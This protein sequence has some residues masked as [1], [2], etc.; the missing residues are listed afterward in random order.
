MKLLAAQGSDEP[1]PRVPVVGVGAE[2]VYLL[3]V[4]AAVLARGKDGLKGQLELGVGA[5][6]PLVIGAL[7]DADDGHLVLDGELLYHGRLL[8]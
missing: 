8:I 3:G 1:I 7:A 4:Q 6:G 2:A 5:L